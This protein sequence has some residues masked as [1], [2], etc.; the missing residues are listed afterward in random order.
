MPGMNERKR[1]MRGE[2]KTA[3]GDYG[4]KGYK[5]GGKVKVMPG[6]GSISSSIS[7]AHKKDRRR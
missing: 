2:T 3:R 7:R 1:H 5:Y 4:T 6:Y